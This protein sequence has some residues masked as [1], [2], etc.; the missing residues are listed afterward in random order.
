[1]K[2]KGLFIFICAVIFSL[3]MGVEAK[4][5]TV[6]QDTSVCS[7]KTL[8]EANAKSSNGDVIVLK[9]NTTVDEVLLLKKELTIDFGGYTVTANKHIVVLPVYD[10]DSPENNSDAIVTFKNGT[11]NFTNPNI[12]LVV[13][14][15]AVKNTVF[16]S[17][18]IE[19]DV[20][21][22][23]MSESPSN[24]SVTAIMVQANQNDAYDTV[25]NVDGVVKGRDIAITLFGETN[26]VSSQ[27]PVINIKENAKLEALDGPAIYAAGYGIWNI[28]GGNIKGSEALSIKS[29]IINISGGKFIATGSYVE[30]PIPSGGPEY[31]G[32][33]ISITSNSSY[34]GNVKLSIFNGEFISENG[35]ALYEGVT[36]ANG[37]AIAYAT[38]INGT[39]TS[40]TGKDSVKITSNS[41][42][43]NGVIT[44]GTFSTTPREE[45]VNSNVSSATLDDGTVLVGSKHGITVGTIENGTVTLDKNAGIK[46][47]LIKLT[48][49]PKEGYEIDKIEI[50]CDGDEVLRTDNGF[51]MPDGDVEI[52]VTFKK[53][54]T[55]PNTFDNSLNTLIIL[56]VC[57]LGGFITYK[58]LEKSAK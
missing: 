41:N 18:T 42:T 58:K 26:V 25:L 48:I 9:E 52:K 45:L 23:N 20:T 27:A 44:G 17:L 36:N 49:T 16:T 24:N 5:V 12:Q 57:A 30:N 37:T 11:I 46:G 55:N 39:F 1:M 53:V 28:S 43:L 2:K 15:V 31:T 13:Q 4:E 21:V 38:I 35:N 32:A 7:Y 51:I 47:E 14:G 19:K 29:G 40:A 3:G 33:A 6:C 34:A 54:I 22:I 8:N 50:L 56:G 10:V